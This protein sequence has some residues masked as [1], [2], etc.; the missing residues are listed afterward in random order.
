MSE[1]KLVERLIGIL[2]EIRADQVVGNLRIEHLAW[3]ISQLERLL[4]PVTQ[5]ATFYGG[6]MSTLPS[7]ITS[8]PVGTSVLLVMTLNIPS[9]VTP[10]AGYTYA[11]QVSTPES[12]VSVSPAT[13]DQTGGAVPLAQQF[14]VTDAATDSPNTTIFTAT[15]PAGFA[16]PLTFPFTWG[17]VTPPPSVS[18]SAAFY[19]VGAAAAAAHRK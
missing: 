11:P 6:T 1:R 12:S 19:P 17:T 4:F 9:G 7:P 16:S 5:I 3:R 8:S 14:I 13:T 18:Q 10:P 2:A 15:D